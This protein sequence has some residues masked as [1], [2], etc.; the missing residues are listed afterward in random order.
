MSVTG[1]RPL[2]NWRRWREETGQ[3]MLEAAVVFPLLVLVAVALVQFALFYHARAVV[4]GAAQDGARVAAAVDATVADGV[5]RSLTLLRAGLGPTAEKVEV[6]GADLGDAIVVRVE[7]RL[8]TII[9]WVADASLPLS[10]QVV[11]SKERF[12]GGPGW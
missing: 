10:A 7:G 3:A 9:P 1:A 11:M 8:P 2:G 6:Q 12:R 5:A 4:T